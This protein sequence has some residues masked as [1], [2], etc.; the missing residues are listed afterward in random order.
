MR[1]ERAQDLR[2]GEVVRC[3]YYGGRTSYSGWVHSVLLGVHRTIHGERYVHV[4]VDDGT[5]R[6]Q[7]WPSW[8]LR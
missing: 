1:V 2:K 6:L 3:P 5:G 4:L 8:R 7:R